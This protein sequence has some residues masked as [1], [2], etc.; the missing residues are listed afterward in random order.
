VGDIGARLSKLENDVNILESRTDELEETVKVLN[1]NLLNK[2]TNKSVEEV[3]V[4]MG[5]RTVNWGQKKKEL[6]KKYSSPA[7]RRESLVEEI[8]QSTDVLDK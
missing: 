7:K 8:V 4:Q 2:A 3:P 1:T 6:E 5:A